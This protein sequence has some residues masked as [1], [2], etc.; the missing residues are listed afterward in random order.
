MLRSLRGCLGAP[1]YLTRFSN[2]HMRR[3]LAA[4]QPTGGHMP[5]RRLVLSLPLFLAAC[6]TP[7]EICVANASQELG[8]LNTL[9]AQ[10]QRDVERGFAIKTEE[11]MVNESQVCGEVAGKKIYC[12]IPVVNTR[13]VPVAIDLVAERAKLNSMIAKQAQLSR[14][15]ESAVA[16]CR[17]RYPEV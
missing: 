13:D 3:I 2:A 7:F 15:A 17:L 9:I 4:M 8:V 5:M 16:D 11:Y 10:K 1:D 6:A 12:D 14:R